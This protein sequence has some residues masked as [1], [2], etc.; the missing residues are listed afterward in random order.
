[1]KNKNTRGSVWHKWDLHI[2]T[3]ASDGTG[4]PQEIVDS[5]I[6]HGLS[7]IAITDHHTAEYIDKVK[8]AAIGK[9]LT[10][11]SGVEFR[12]EYGSKSVHFIAYFPDKYKGTVLDSKAIHDMVLCKLGLS[13]TEIITKGK[14][15]NESLN[16]D[17]AFK[18]GTFLVQVDFKKSCDLVHSYGGLISVH[19][20]SKENGLDSE[21]KHN[22]SGKTNVETLYDSLGVLKEELMTRY[23]DICDIGKEKDFKFY[24]EKFN[25]PSII[26]SDAHKFSDIGSRFTWIKS[27]LTFEGFKQILYEPEDRVCLNEE[28]PDLKKDYQ[29]ID[30]I[31]FDNSEMGKQEI[32][33]NQNLNTVI[34]GRSSGKSILLGCIANAID[35]KINPKSNNAAYNK[36]IKELN[37]GVSVR[38]RDKTSEQRKVIYYSQSEISDKVRND[39]YGVSGINELIENIVKKDA[40]KL[41]LLKKYEN[42]LGVN[43]TDINT[44]INSFCQYKNQIEELNKQME[45]IGN[46]K[47][48]ENEIVKIQNEIETVKKNINGYLTQE[49]DETYKT[50]KKQLLD[51]KQAQNN[52]L[53]DKNQ[54]QLLKTFS[55][56]SSIETVL[57]KF[58]ETS[59]KTIGI[60]N[61][62]SVDLVQKTV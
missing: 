19:N 8:A 45:S 47:G 23:I 37:N 22:G 61:I 39:E 15:Q 43:K 32:K 16:D 36:H 29:I 56:F 51:F 58:S 44:K 28:E 1:M 10:V 55:L 34:G 21:V 33:F 35:S 40:E 50:Y 17:E 52:F 14:I 30:S 25:R 7:G 57:S 5:A 11:I 9:N 54:Y 59:Y 38:W 49:E 26:T 4:T 18:K 60:V 48:I 12:S 24:L 62:S 6:S 3:P 13:K 31:T 20:G 27:D 53:S 2:H 41:E 46:K 42:F